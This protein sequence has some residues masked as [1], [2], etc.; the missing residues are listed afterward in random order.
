MYKTVMHLF[1]NHL[2]KKRAPKEYIKVLRKAITLTNYLHY[3]INSLLCQYAV[4]QLVSYII[5]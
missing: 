3:I 4:G 1:P 5:H 2:S